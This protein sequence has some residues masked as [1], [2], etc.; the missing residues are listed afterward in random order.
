MGEELIG[1]GLV[2]VRSALGK[3]TASAALDFPAKQQWVGYGMNHL[4]LLDRPEV[5]VRVRRWLG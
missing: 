4:D 3:G 2:P 5:Y 1:D